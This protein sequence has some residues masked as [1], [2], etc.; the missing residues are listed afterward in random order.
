[1]PPYLLTSARTRLR[2]V[3]KEKFVNASTVLRRLS[4]V[5]CSVALVTGMT[6][7][8][9]SAEPTGA[10][11]VV[12]GGHE[13]MPPAALNGRAADARDAALVSQ[14]LFAVVVADG[15]PFVVPS[16]VQLL[17]RD[18][19]SQVQERDRD[20]N[21]EGI[22]AMLAEA[23]AKTPE[24]DLLTG[25]DLAARGLSS[26]I[27]DRTILAVHSGLSTT[28]ALDFAAEP[29]L[30]DADPESLAQG[31]AEA[32]ELPNLAGLRVVFQG[33][34]DT[35][36]PQPALGQRQRDNLVAI[37]EAIVRAAGATDVL[38]EQTPLSGRPDPGLPEVS[39]VIPGPG[40]SCTV[41]TVVLDEEAVAFEAETAEF[42]AIDDVRTMLGP[43][44]D[45]MVAEGLSATLTGTT[46]D[47][48]DADG[49]QQLS[50][51]RAEAVARVLRDA[52]V[53]ADQLTGVGLGSEFPG[54]DADNLA[55]NRKVSVALSATAPGVSCQ[56]A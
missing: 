8:G 2:R 52:G 48:G 42:L 37:W 16:P 10:L 36:A 18:E 17:A 39:Q 45:R 25:L 47:V 12:V 49:Q 23:Q 50:L 31:L 32:G 3:P 51:L 35:V 46:A 11:A 33:L 44:A 56:A 4:A 19:N 22:D 40:P 38:V 43:I 13:H 29:H 5:A 15:E 27:G 55:E 53:A 54:Y 30:L 28:G 34:G 20:R 1:M 9:E 24:T 21:R 41:E 7:C 6:A 14:A 26:G